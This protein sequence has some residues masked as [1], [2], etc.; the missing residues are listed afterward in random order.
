MKRRTRK[1]RRPT[2][3]NLLFLIAV[4]LGAGVLPA[5]VTRG[6]V[7]GV[8]TDESGGTTLPGAQI[9]AVHQSTGTR[10]TAV[11]DADGRFTIHG[12]RVGAYQVSATM[13]GFK[14]GERT[15][16]V[17]LGQTVF[18]TFGL[19]LETVTEVLTVVGESGQLINPARTGAASNVSL[20]SIENLPTIGR[21]LEDFAR[22]NPFFTVTAENQDAPSLSVAGRNNRYN[23]IQI[24]GS[25]NNDLF[26]L[27]DQ[28][29]PGGQAN[30]TPISLDAIQE[31][32]LVIADFDVRQGGFS[33]GSVNVVTRSGTNDYRGSA[34]FF[35][36]DDGFFG[37]GPAVLGEFG[38]FEED[39]Y[40][41]RFGGP[42]RQDKVFFFL[43]YEN[44]EQSTP[45]GWSIDGASG[46]AFGNGGLIDEANRF[47]D[48]LISR[49]GF[50][51]GGLG[52]NTRSTPSDKAF[53]RLDFN[54]SDRHQLTLR[55]NFVD[56]QNDVNR[57]G[58]RT[59]EWPSETYA[60]TD[61]TNSTVAQLNSVFG[62]NRFNELRITRQS[63]RDARAGRDANPFPWIEIENVLPNSGI[64]FEAGTEA[65]SQRNS[66]DQDI[67]EITN[68]FTWVRGDHTV[69]LGTHNELFSF[70]NVFV[71]N[72]FGA[73]EFTD[74]DAF[75]AG[76]ARR[77]NLTLI[78][79]GQPEIQEFD[80]D[81]I[82][83]YAGDTWTVRPDLTLTYGLRVDVPF[84]PDK[85]SRNPLTE[86]LYGLHTDEIPD[87]NAL[88]Q[89]RLGFNWDVTGEGRQQLRG[90]AG[91]FAGRTPYV[92]I[93]NNYARTGIE[94]NFITLTNVPF[95]PDPLG[96]N[97]DLTGANLQVGEFNLIDPD[98][99]FPQV[100]RLNLAYD[101]ELSWWGLF[102]SAEILYSQTLEDID[103]KN[104]NVS[105]TGTTQPFDGRPIYSSINPSVSGAY[106]ITNTGEG[107][108]TNIALRIERPLRNRVS[109][110]VSYVYGDSQVV[111]PGTSSR[112]VS[113]WQFHE[114]TDPNNAEVNRS[115]FEVEHR[116]NASASYTF[117]GD[118]EHPTVLSAYYNLQS[119]RPYSTLVTGGFPFTSINGD[120]FTSNDLIYVPS[121]AGDVV[122][123]G[124]TWEQLDAYISSDKCLDRHRGQIAPR[125]CSEAPWNHTLDLRLAQDVPIPGRAK[126]QLTLDVL[127]VMNL[128]D[129]DS[130]VLRYVNFN[131]ITPVR[132]D[133]IDPET[134]NPIYTLF[135]VVTDPENNPVFQTHNINSRWR[136]KLGARVSF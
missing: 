128:L 11:S 64:E 50:D 54:L 58:S 103:Y 28:G 95:N 33:G 16:S 126:L 82:G 53:A 27:A 48:I 83:L 42:L 30:T 72:A 71:Q 121:G 25:V 59:Y 2:P 98:F 127:N 105:P 7:A 38:Q 46:Q 113:N 99:E 8:V 69:T 115:E 36:R 62:S 130:G 60:F 17:S 31:L 32:E 43:N 119:G 129:D 4:I 3:T 61:E 14:S 63:I 6:G 57:P 89:P 41:F 135:R 114:A 108:S 66:L 124:G 84:M 94:Q 125:N 15:V 26:G 134:G 132:F 40:G 67:L 9:L 86:S 118:T 77:Y 79:P 88:W 122:T 104:V 87:G 92:W 133:G 131:T 56:A 37:D 24:D 112:A 68:D 81:Q 100:L 52:E 93:S 10:H 120:G 35:T 80:I 45:S 13:D 85:P 47:R 111:N 12:V 107:E 49:Y 102:G 109:G 97:P 136:A 65:F 1:E 44:S 106:L 74:L 116:F 96:Q 117:G 55:H 5:Q 123:R 73:Y 23:N 39:V 75:E 76:I 101:R 34:Y 22:T 110:Y 21:G 20:E 19:H 51:P 29:T 90:G 18:L 70:A 78:N 91:I